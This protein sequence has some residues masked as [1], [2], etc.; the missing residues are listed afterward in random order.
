[1]HKFQL[2]TIFMLK[3][4]ILKAS[5]IVSYKIQDLATDPLG[6]HAKADDN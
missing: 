5:F 1:M 6:S 4:D 3:L 2:T